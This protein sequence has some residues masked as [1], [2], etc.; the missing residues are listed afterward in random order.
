MRSRW[1]YN[2]HTYYAEVHEPGYIATDRIVRHRV[3]VWS[4]AS[5]DWR[6]IWSGTTESFNPNSSRDVNRHIA[7]LIVPELASQGFVAR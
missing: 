3:D 5:D 4:T 6:L 2:Y 1:S 7:K